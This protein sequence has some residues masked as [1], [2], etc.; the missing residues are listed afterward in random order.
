MYK[1]YQ[2]VLSSEDGEHVQEE[3]HTQPEAYKYIVV[4]RPHYGDGQELSIK[5]IYR[6]F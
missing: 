1:V 5:P 6:G 3:F 4:N 2:V